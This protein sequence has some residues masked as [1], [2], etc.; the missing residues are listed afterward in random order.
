MQ[1]YMKILIAFMPKICS[2][3]HICKVKPQPYQPRH[4]YCAIDQTFEVGVVNVV[5]KMTQTEIWVQIFFLFL[6][7]FDLLVNHNSPSSDDS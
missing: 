1:S 4:N 7:K 6:Q 2:S 5:S 3:A